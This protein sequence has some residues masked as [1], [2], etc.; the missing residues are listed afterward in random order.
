MASKEH[1]KNASAIPQDLTL[2]QTYNA[3]AGRRL[4]GYTHITNSSGARE[5]WS[6]NNGFRTQIMSNLFE[7]LDLKPH[8]NITKELKS[9]QIKK[10]YEA[11]Q[12]FINEVRKNIN[13]FNVDEND[14][15][16]LFN[17]NTEKA[18]TEEAVDFLLNADEIGR[19][20]KEEFI[21]E[22]A[23]S[24]DRF[25][26]TIKKTKVQNFAKNNL[27]KKV[28]G[29]SARKSFGNN[30]AKRFIWTNTRN[31]H[32]GKCRKTRHAKAVDVPFDTNSIG[33][34]PFRWHCL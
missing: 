27:K 5:R 24:E 25:E 1:L 4:G 34:V 30:H 2:E 28:T 29:Y 11:V 22:C 33:P 18:A 15:K 9:H 16:T 12:R 6:R 31:C 17:I 13:P 21:N 20:K 23:E 3:D 14:F 7:E 8:K 19:K 32:G 26:K 10:D